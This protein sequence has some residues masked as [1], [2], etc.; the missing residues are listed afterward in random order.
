MDLLRWKQDLEDDKFI[1]DEMI[2]EARNITI[3]RD[4]KLND[5]KNLIKNKIENP[6]NNNNNKFLIFSSFADT[7][8]YLY[9][10]ISKY[11][12]EEYFIETALV[13]GA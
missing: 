8:K 2:S 12:K 10:N 4:S 3:D 11:V 1:L 13:T 7:A 5:L 9:E 6:I